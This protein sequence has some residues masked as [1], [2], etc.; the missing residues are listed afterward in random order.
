MQFKVMKVF[1]EFTNR[2]SR[3][4]F[5]F[6]IKYIQI[7]IILRERPRTSGRGWIARRVKHDL[8]FLVKIK[9][10]PFT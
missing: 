2:H 4:T 1:F 9:G 8:A 5:S 10:K 6:P 3:L 7:I